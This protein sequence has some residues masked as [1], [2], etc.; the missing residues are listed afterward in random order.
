MSTIYGFPLGEKRWSFS[1]F[2]T[3]FPLNL[4]CPAFGEVTAT[5]S[6]H[7]LNA[8]VL[9]LATVMEYFKHKADTAFS[10]LPLLTG[11]GSAVSYLLS[12]FICVKLKL[13]ILIA[14][15]V[16]SFLCFMFGERRFKNREVE[17]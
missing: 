10:V 16:F 14:F 13:S 6:I 3:T 17:T 11:L 15:T 8:F 1:S 5:R 7:L 12:R 2:T 9:L 4:T